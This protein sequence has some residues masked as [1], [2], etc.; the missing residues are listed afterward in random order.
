M[1]LLKNRM[2][3]S[4]EDLPSTLGVLSETPQRFTL[5]TSAAMSHGLIRI[6][7]KARHSITCANHPSSYQPFPGTRFQGFHL[8]VI[9]PA[10]FSNGSVF[11]TLRITA[12][13][14]HAT[15][16]GVSRS[17]EYPRMQ[18]MPYPDSGVATQI[19]CRVSAACRRDA[20]I[21]QGHVEVKTTPSRQ[22]TPQCCA[23]VGRRPGC[24]SSS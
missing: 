15:R 6:L 7:T 4:R 11:S 23:V 3:G 16:N 9:R 17:A 22:A 24:R 14:H 2:S 10:W 21:V 8:Q 5:D 12:V 20:M 19:T 1:R 18:R 13:D